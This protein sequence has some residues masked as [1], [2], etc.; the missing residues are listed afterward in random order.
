MGI[1]ST[2][3]VI[4]LRSLRRFFYPSMFSFS[5]FFLVIHRLLEKKTRARKHGGA[6]MN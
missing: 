1:M 3:L 2:A 4:P 6:C 5:H